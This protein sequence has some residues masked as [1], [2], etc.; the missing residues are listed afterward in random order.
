MIALA[1]TLVV[2]LLGMKWLEN[3]SENN[4]YRR[5]AEELEKQLADCRKEKA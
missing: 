2:F 4:E 5:K 3:Q 1:I